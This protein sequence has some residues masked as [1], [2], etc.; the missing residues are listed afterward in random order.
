PRSHGASAGRDLSR[1][2]RRVA[3]GSPGGIRAAG[4]VAAG[5]GRSSDSLKRCRRLGE[6][7][8]HHGE[9][10]RPREQSSAACQAYIL[11]QMTRLSEPPLRRKWL[12]F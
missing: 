2:W 6:S 4:Q 10:P 1:R 5:G 7:P 3:A 11:L 8:R 12:D 9:H